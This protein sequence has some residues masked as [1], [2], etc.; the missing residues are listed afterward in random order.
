[1]LSVARLGTPP[2]PCEKQQLRGGP[3]RMRKIIMTVEMILCVS[4]KNREDVIQSR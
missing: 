4:R 1:M 3:L 2:P